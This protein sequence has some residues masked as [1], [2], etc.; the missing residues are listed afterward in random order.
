MQAIDI[1]FNRYHVG[2]LWFDVAAIFIL[3]GVPGSLLI[4]WFHGQPG[5]QAIQRKEIALQAAL[6]AVALFFCQK[7]YRAA[8]GEAA[9]DSLGARSIAVLPFRN[10]SDSRSDEY[11]SE[12]IAEDVLTH[13]ARFGDL[14]VASRTTSMRYRGSTKSSRQIAGEIGVEHVLEGS[15]RKEGSRVRVTARLIRARTDE[16]LWSETYDRELK[17]IFDLQSELAGKIAGRL[18]VRM[19]GE[20]RAR[21]SSRPTSDV[22]AYQDLLRGRYYVERF[23]PDGIEEGIRWYQAAVDKDPLLGEAYAGLALAH[24]VSGLYFEIGRA[25]V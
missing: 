22:E 18:E 14:R 6:L 19:T 16:E 23:T 5:S 10:L 17:D 9:P 25:H 3:C 15:V 21:L 7:A 12:G 8:P 2:Q 20:E 11:F 13:L 4:A 1:V 24:G